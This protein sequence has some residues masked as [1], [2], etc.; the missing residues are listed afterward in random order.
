MASLALAE[1]LVL[2]IILTFWIAFF[3]I[4]NVNHTKGLTFYLNFLLLKPDFVGSHWFCLFWGLIYPRPPEFSRMCKRACE[5]I[6]NALVHMRS[7]DG[8]KKKRE[9]GTQRPDDQCTGRPSYLRTFLLSTQASDIIVCPLRSPLPRLRRMWEKK[10]LVLILS[11]KDRLEPSGDTAA[12][13]KCP[14]YKMQC[15]LRALCQTKP[16]HQKANTVHK[17]LLE[18]EEYW[19]L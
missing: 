3:Q 15:K 5:Q 1:N 4:I 7:I 8:G 9:N 6:P 10:M 17:Q 12:L 14:I 11:K 18:N 19:P 13:Q 16:L 2:T